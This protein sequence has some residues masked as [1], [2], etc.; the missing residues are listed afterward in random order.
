MES[1]NQ[2][3]VAENTNQLGVKSGINNSRHK[4]TL[5][6]P[7]LYAQLKKIAYSRLHSYQQGITLNCTSLVHEAFLKIRGTSHQFNDENHYLAVASMAMRQILVD[8][9]RCK[10]SAKRGAGAIHITLQESKI[11]DDAPNVDLLELNDA[12]I[13]LSE[14][15]PLLEKLVVLRFFAGL[16]VKQTAE[17]LGRSTRSAERDWTRARVYLYREL[18]ANGA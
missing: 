4:E 10:K 14:R 13:A 7:E 1:S 2:Q 8:Y 15:D 18:A 5:L 11:K 12:L 3:T 16:N 17:I 9:A 6:T